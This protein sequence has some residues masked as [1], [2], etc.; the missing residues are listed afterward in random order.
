[1]TDAEISD[2]NEKVGERPGEE[3]RR[4]SDVSGHYRQ[5]EADKVQLDRS[6]GWVV[7][8]EMYMNI[9][10]TMNHTMKYNPRALPNSFWSAKAEMTPKPGIKDNA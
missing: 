6:T 1:M 4:K 5:P 3:K 10:V 2:P 8:G 7:A 9:T